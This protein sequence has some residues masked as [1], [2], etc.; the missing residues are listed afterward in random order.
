[1]AGRV[2]VLLGLVLLALAPDRSRLSARGRLVLVLLRLAAF[3]ALVFCLLRPSIV[4][5]SRTRQQATLLLLA[6]GSESMTVAD[7]PNGQSRW[8]HLR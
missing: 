1:M 6:D 3:L 4:A 7:G 8:D 5:S 2:T